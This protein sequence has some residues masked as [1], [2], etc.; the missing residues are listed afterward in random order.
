M[1]KNSLYR[2]IMIIQL[3]LVITMFISCGGKKETN[4]QPVDQYNLDNSNNYKFIFKDV[5]EKNREKEEK[6][7]KGPFDD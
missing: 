2:L 6:Y 5:I 4:K 3:M 7:R 1:I